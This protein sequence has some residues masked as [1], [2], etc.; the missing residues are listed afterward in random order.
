MVEEHKLS[1]T[2]RLALDRTQLANERTLLAYLRTF[3]GLVASGAAMWKLI[4]MGWARIV[5]V[6]FFVC[7][8]ITVVAG[9]CRFNRERKRLQNIIK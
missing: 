8:P 5:A 2:D 4:D 1:L 3:I 7:A 9:F 6:L